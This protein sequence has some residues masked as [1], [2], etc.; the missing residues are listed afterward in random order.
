MAIQQRAVRK[1]DWWNIGLWAAQLVLALVFGSAGVMKLFMPIET[2]GTSLNWVTHSPALLVRFIGE[3]VAAYGADPARVYLMG[4][5]QGA[6]M[7]GWVALTRPELVAG[8]AL[9]S[10][11]VPEELREQIAE[12][13]Q[14]AG[15]PLLVI[16]GTRDEVLPI[17]NGRAS[18]DL[19]QRLPVDLTYREYPMGHEVSAQPVDVDE[20][21]R[22]SGLGAREVR[23]ALVE[24]DLAGRIERHGAQLVSRAYP[25]R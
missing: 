6:M 18:R 9:M 15:K 14:L 10:G 25:D 17:Q 8:A 23:I 22:A 16:H 4:F 11:R 2:L 7:S 1:I 24:L 21:I 13:E 3:A 19:L 20:L 12:P 5:S